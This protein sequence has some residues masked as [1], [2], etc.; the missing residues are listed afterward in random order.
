MTGLSAPSILNNIQ[1]VQAIAGCI[2]LRAS[3][4]ASQL[5]E[6]IAQ[7]I[8]QHPGIY[9]V[10]KDAITG[11]LIVLFDPNI[12]P[13]PQVLTIL[14][15]WGVTG[16]AIDNNP[17]MQV[18]GFLHQHHEVK[19]LLPM[20]AGML[21]TQTFRLRGGWALLANLMAASFTSQA[22]EQFEKS[23][24]SVQLLPAT[25]D[26]TPT[27]IAIPQPTASPEEISSKS[28]VQVIHAI[29]GRL[30]LR[31]TSMIEDPEYAR[32]F[33]KIL[34]KEK[35]ITDFRLNSQAASIVVEYESDG[36]SDREIQEY[37]LNLL[38]SSVAENL[39]AG[40]GNQVEQNIDVNLPE[41]VPQPLADVVKLESEEVKLEEPFGCFNPKFAYAFL[42]SL[43]RHFSGN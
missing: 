31:A 13:L 4:N 20:I 15:Q 27:A 2:Q 19:S 11:N 17:M 29:P 1:V 24:T 42:N 36:I 5:L 16:V 41:T 10:H 40:N 8:R 21:L 12:I 23:S 6:I 22:L 37:L 38:S 18:G 25:E 33:Q 28:A 3:E 30:R 26:V 43:A 35:L 7:Q 32:T 14:Q 9:S 39:N 34:S